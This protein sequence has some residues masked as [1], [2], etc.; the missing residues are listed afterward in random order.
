MLRGW[1]GEKRDSAMGVLGKTLSGAQRLLCVCEV[2]GF[3]VL[4][5]GQEFQTQG[6]G[7]WT[8]MDELNLPFTAANG[9]NGGADISFLRAER[10]VVSLLAIFCFFCFFF[11]PT[12]ALC[13]FQ[14]AWRS[15][16][17]F[18][19]GILNH[20]FDD[21]EKFMAKL[22]QTAEAVTV[23]NQKKK[24]K[25]KSKKQSVEGEKKRWKC[26]F[27][28]TAIVTLN[29]S[30]HILCTNVLC[31]TTEDLLSAKARPPPE[32]EFIDIFQKFKYCF[33]LLVCT[34]NQIIVFSFGRPTVLDVK[35]LCLC[36]RPAWN[37]PSRALPQRSSFTTCSNPWI[38]WASTSAP[39]VAIPMSARHC[40]L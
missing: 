23:L 17:S 19:Q 39:V 12:P 27:K 24:K 11:L 1:K 30:C 7:P 15:L 4:K 31:W 13:I 25:K 28:L 36:L 9:I 2:G 32:E 34:F 6:P 40:L 26:A 29:N 33:S 16:S 14:A 18:P 38:W 37:W 21:I 5:G 20:C 35:S 8:K 10:E 22:Q 3:Q